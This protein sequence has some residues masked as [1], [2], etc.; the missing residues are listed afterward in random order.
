MKSAFDFLSL[1]NEDFKEDSVR[2]FILAPLLQKLGF[3]NRNLEN[4]KPKNHKEARQILKGAKYY[5]HALDSEFG[6]IATQK[7]Q[8]STLWIPQ[9]EI[10]PKG[11]D[12]DSVLGLFSK[13]QLAEL[14]LLRKLIF[15]HTTPSGSKENRILKRNLRYSLMLAFYNTL[16]MCNKTFHETK[17]RKGKAGVC[18]IFAYYRYRRSNYC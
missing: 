6:E 1:E 9:D 5:P 11:S 18:G 16:T 14:A 3:V 13:M 10:L 4:P 15:K 2:E 17:L 7:E 12:V 8:D